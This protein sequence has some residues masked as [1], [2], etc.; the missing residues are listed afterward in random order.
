VALCRTL[1]LFQGTQYAYAFETSYRLRSIIFCLDLSDGANTVATFYATSIGSVIGP[2]YVLPSLKYLARVWFENGGVWF[3]ACLDFRLTNTF[4][5]EVELRQAC[6]ILFDAVTVRMSDAE[7][8][9][10]IEHWQH[11]C[12]QSSNIIGVCH[13]TLVFF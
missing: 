9:T 6:R 10:T 11:D 1:S 7:A 3:S 4:S 5:V 13:L 2:N 12:M 8:G